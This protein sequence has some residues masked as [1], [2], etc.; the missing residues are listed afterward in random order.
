MAQDAEAVACAHGFLLL[1]LLPSLNVHMASVAAAVTYP[2]R[3]QA[4]HETCKTVLLL[5]LLSSLKDINDIHDSRVITKFS[6][7][8]HTYCCVWGKD[9]KHVLA[10]SDDGTVRVVL[11][12]SCKVRLV[13]NR[14]ED[15]LPWLAT[16]SSS[17]VSLGTGGARWA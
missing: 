3:Q 14:G 6:G 1:Q 4:A 5:Q 11:V 12:P 15:M 13:F 10:A 17:C 9:G 16:C 7:G 2:A 8:L